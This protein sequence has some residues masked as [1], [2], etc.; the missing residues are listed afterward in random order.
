MRKKQKGGKD[1]KSVKVLNT[2]IANIQKANEDAGVTVTEKSD[3]D[4]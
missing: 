2:F 4:N 3:K 1:R